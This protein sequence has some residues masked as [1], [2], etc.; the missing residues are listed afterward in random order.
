MH[1]GSAKSLF[2]LLKKHKKRQVNLE[3]DNIA[4]AFS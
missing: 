3:K 1:R 4:G 2:L